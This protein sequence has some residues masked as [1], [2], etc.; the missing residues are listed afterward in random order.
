MMKM[1]QPLAVGALLNLPNNP[2]GCHRLHADTGR[3][4]DKVHFDRKDR[5]CPECNL[6]QQV[7]DEHRFLF[8]CPSS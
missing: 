2:S 7:Q 8:D 5:P 6:A 1:Q 3:W 4:E